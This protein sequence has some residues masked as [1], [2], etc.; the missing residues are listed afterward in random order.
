MLFVDLPPVHESE[1]V[2]SYDERLA[3]AFDVNLISRFQLTD[4]GICIEHGFSFVFSL[5]VS[6]L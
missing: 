1:I 6:S 3:I 5:F 2:T 4:S